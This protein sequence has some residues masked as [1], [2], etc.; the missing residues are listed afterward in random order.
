MQ[1]IK[2]QGGHTVIQDAESCVVFGMGQV[3]QSLGCV[4]KVVD[5]DKI[6]EYLIR[7]TNRK[8]E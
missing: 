4:D 7:V 2:Q 3:A 1:A 5:L 8:T 6:A